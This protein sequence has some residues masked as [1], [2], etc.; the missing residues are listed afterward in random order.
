[1][2]QSHAI[3]TAQ[4]GPLNVAVFPDETYTADVAGART[5]GVTTGLVLRPEGSG[6]DG[7]GKVS[8]PQQTQPTPARVET[9]RN[10][11]GKGVLTEEAAGRLMSGGRVRDHAWDQIKRLA[12]GQ[13]DATAAVTIAT[14]DCW[15]L[16]F[17]TAAGPRGFDFE[18]LLHR[19]N[20]PPY[21]AILEALDALGR[22]GWRM[23]QVSEDRKVD[24]AAETSFIVA[25]R[26][27][28]V[29]D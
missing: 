18:P 4:K 28:F 9:L 19:H 14:L 20:E 23:F 2:S 8:D 6:R 15:T 29:R 10:L 13:L 16:T 25:I 3:L 24:V 1:M 17:Q 22:D 11:V 21:P 26:Y 7:D 27:L 12:N 5:G